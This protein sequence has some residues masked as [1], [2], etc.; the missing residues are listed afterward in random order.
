M[1]VLFTSEIKIAYSAYIYL[2][3]FRT[4]QQTLPHY[5]ECHFISKK[6]LAAT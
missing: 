2:R 3:Y 1:A 5:Q 4:Q 6:R